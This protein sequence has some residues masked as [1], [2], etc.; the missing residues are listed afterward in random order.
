MSYKCKPN[1]GQALSRNNA[2][3]LNKE[4]KEPAKPG[5]NCRAGVDNC[6]FN[7]QCQMDNVIYRAAV[8]TD[9]G[10]TEYYT[11]KCHF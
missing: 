6:P 11:H 10:K 2:K 8:T 4:R 9:N 3:L 7:G 1:I 5:C